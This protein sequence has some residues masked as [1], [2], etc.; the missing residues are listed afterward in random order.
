MAN[1][2]YYDI[3]G[4]S[5]GATEKEI[6]SAFRKKAAAFHPDKNKDPNAANEF[7]K[8]N[9]A[10]QIL[11]D[12]A[13]RKTYDQY[14][15]AAFQNGGAGGNPFGNGQ[16]FEFDFS[17]IFGGGGFDNV[18][19]GGSPFGDLF[20]RAN[21]TENV[22][23]GQDIS[24]KIKV[25][26]NDVLHGP[27][28]EIKF[29]RKEKC[30]NCNG[31][32][33]SKIETCKTCDGKGRVMQVARSLFGNMQV[34][35]AC[36]ECNGTGKRIIEKCNV[37]AGQSIVQGVKTMKIRIPQGIESGL[38][39]RFKGEGDAGK[40]NSENGDLYIE[41]EVEPDKRFVRKG[42]HLTAHF[43]LPIYSLV[44][45]DEIIVSTLDGDKKVKVPQ[46]LEIG[47]KLV[48]KNLGLPNIRTKSRGDF[49][50]EIT[51]E[52]PKKL[53]REEQSYFEKLRGLAKEKKDKRFW[54]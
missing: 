3:L 26:L 45:G 15:S 36:P 42:D 46:G 29:E 50:I 20:G 14:G 27:E 1:S 51:V 49:I 43:N 21:T 54:G 11:S 37:C 33:G 30:K 7:K 31:F 16:G 23:R 5:K 13:K 52:I 2:D 4:V 9:E 24:L 48:L 44:L 17:D 8:I 38:S 22:N 12:P 34:N 18:F 28:K 25:T 41:I 19:G 35:R 10:Y 47:E 40:F 32:G 6:K 39:L 53:S